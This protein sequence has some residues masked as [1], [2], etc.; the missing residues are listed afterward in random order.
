MKKYDR[1]MDVCT[2]LSDRIVRENSPDLNKKYGIRYTKSLLDFMI[3]MRGYGQN[4]NRQY[5]IFSATFGGPSVRHLR[6]LVTKS[7]DA[8]TNPALIYENMARVRRYLDSVKYNG[9]IIIGSDCTKV[10]KRLNFSSEHG[11]HILGTVFDLQDVEVE[12]AEDIDM[13]VDRATT[14]N[15][16]ASQ[17]RAIIAKVCLNFISHSVYS[18]ELLNF[19]SDPTA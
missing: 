17:A 8:L 13:I 12:D 16:F 1:V 2:A 7:S 14:E 10:R 18:I 3:I 9:P 11:A 15:G 6:T 4:S 5:G 19:N